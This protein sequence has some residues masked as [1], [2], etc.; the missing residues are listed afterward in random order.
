[1]RSNRPVIG[2]TG[3]D[4]GGTVAWGF[5]RFALWLHGARAIRIRPMKKGDPEHLDG[6]ILGGGADIHPDRYGMAL[7]EALK[8][9][10]PSTRLRWWERVLSFLFY[11]VILLARK[12]F[13]TRHPGIDRN[14]DDLEFE[15]LEQAI[16]RSIPVLGICRGAQLMNIHFGGSLHQDI[17]EFY[18][19]TPRIYSVWPRKRV[20]LAEGS[21]LRGI[22]KTAVVYVNALHHQAVN[23]IGQQLNI[24]GEE[25]AGLVQAIEHPGFNFMIGVQWHPEYMP[26]IPL[27]R[28]LFRELVRQAS[29]SPG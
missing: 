3:P 21:Q 13:S 7:G 22:L 16:S 17:S 11:P 12:L 4:E 23:T 19:E 10:R 20:W 2:V 8:S 24:V 26:Q 15:M 25:R 27:Q 1:M 18:T 5:T 9:A 29:R 14:R 6:L 28:R